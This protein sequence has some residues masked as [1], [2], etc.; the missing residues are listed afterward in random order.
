MKKTLLAA[1]LVLALGTGTANA[2]ILDSYS[3]KNPTDGLYYTVDTLDW[4]S[5]GSGFAQGLTPGAINVGTA[6]TFNYQAYLAGATLNGGAV[7]GLTNGLNSSF[8]YTIVAKFGEIVIDGATGL[9]GDSAT[10]MTTGGTWGIYAGASNA[11]VST[12]TGFDDGALV[13]KG[14]IGAGQYSSFLPTSATSGI[15][16]TILLG[17]IDTASINPFYLN[18]LGTSGQQLI[19]FRYEGTQN[20]PAGDSTTSGFFIGGDGVLFPDL[21]LANETGIL[22]KVD[23]S[24][25]LGVVPEPSTYLLFSIG[26]MGI[27]GYCKRRKES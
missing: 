26:L 21:L 11:V 5:S 25:K 1:T 10:F 4:S 16:S 7:T 8:E 22:F 18:P 27:V 24:N 3:I 17:D 20:I 13:V 19:D 9:P 2:L 14:T 12:G 23:G 15:G 6:F